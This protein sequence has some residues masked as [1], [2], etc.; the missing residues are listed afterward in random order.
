MD[1]DKTKTTDAPTGD[2]PIYRSTWFTLPPRFELKLFA[3]VLLVFA[4]CVVL[5]LFAGSETSLQVD[6][7]ARMS[8]DFSLL[9]P[10]LA[11]NFGA[12][13]MLFS[14]V[15]TLGVLPVLGTIVIGLY[16]GTVMGASVFTLG[17][18]EAAV[19]FL[20]FVL[21]ELVGI[22]MTATAGLLPGAAAV[23]S[24]SRGFKTAFLAYLNAFASA[25][26]WLAIGGV[27][28]LV[29]AVIEVLGGIPV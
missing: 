20:P 12:A 3:G 5:G 17:V 10:I 2:T 27:L 6:R 23:R 13:L 9:F 29:G 24:S 25:L 16:A 18:G 19:R 11:S 1:R 8:S 15:I 22:C 14:G 21:L 26:R 28:L 4:A 7:G